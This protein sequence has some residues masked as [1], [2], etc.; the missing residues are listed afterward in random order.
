MAAG[1]RRPA[2]RRG[3]RRSAYGA[4][5]S[6]SDITDVLRA[7]ADLEA[8]EREL[9]LL[10]THA[11]DLIARHQVD[12]KIVYAAGGAEALLGFEAKHLVGFWAADVC[13]PDDAAA[14]REAHEQ[15]RR[16]ASAAWSA[17]G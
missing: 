15:A 1:Q 14:V 8:R 7:Q 2:L 9:A 12:G 6:F 10:A 3:R 4:V 11:G 16:R 17:T 13:H 5:V